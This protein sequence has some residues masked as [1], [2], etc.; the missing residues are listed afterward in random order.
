MNNIERQ[1][2]DV[3]ADIM[4]IAYDINKLDS[5]PIINIA[6][7]GQEFQIHTYEGNKCHMKI[8]DLNT[9]SSRTM[10]D[11]LFLKANLVADLVLKRG[12]IYATNRKAD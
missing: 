5:S 12:G 10:R 1:N 4:E 6:L 11:L 7:N 2:I 8:I 3:I 9:N